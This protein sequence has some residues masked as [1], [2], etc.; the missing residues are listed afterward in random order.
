MHLRFQLV[1]IAVFFISIFQSSAQVITITDPNFR[2]ALLTH[3]P[4]ID[5]NN[6][7]L[8]QV[9]EALAAEQLYL[10]NRNIGDLTGISAFSNLK[11]LSVNNN[12]LSSID[13]SQNIKLTGFECSNN[14]LTNIDVSNN[15]ALMYFRCYGNN[16]SSIDLSANTDLRELDISSNNLTSLNLSVNPLLTHLNFS[17]NP[18]TAIN[19]KQHTE[20]ISLRCTNTSLTALDLSCNNSLLMAFTDPSSA[21]NSICLNST[22]YAARTDPADMFGYLWTKSAHTSWTNCPSLPMVTPVPATIVSVDLCETGDMTFNA[23]SESFITNPT[24][25][26]Q[27]ATSA[28]GPWVNLPGENNQKLVLTDLQ[29]TDNGSIYKVLISSADYCGTGHMEEAAGKIVLHPVVYPEVLAA[30]S[31]TGAVCDTIQQITYTATPVAGQ[32]SAPA[33]QWYYYTNPTFTPISG[34]NDIQYTPAT[35]PPNGSQLFVGMFTDEMCAVESGVPSNILTVKILPTP[36]PVI[37]TADIALCNPSG[38]VIQTSQTA[39][40]GTTFQWYKNGIAIAASNTRN[41]TISSEGTY[42]MKENNGTCEI[43]SGSVTIDRTSHVPDPQVTVSSSLTGPACDTLQRITYT[44]TPVPGTVTNPTYQWYDATTNTAI[45]GATNAVFT[46][47]TKPMN[48]DKV[49]V[50]V[51]TDEA[52]VVNPDVQSETVTT[53]ILPTPAPVMVSVSTALC[54]PAGHQLQTSNIAATGAQIIW[55]ENGNAITNSNA[56]TFTIERPGTYHITESNGVCETASA[57]VTISALTAAADPQVT[58]SSSLTGP[59]CDTLQR[60]TYTATP[61]PGTVA[62][63]TYQWYDATT[64]TAITGATNAVFTPAT[65]PMNGEKVYVIV[66]TNEACV[67][68]PDVQSETVTTTILP[69]PAPVMTSVSTALCNPAGHQL[70]TSNIAATGAQIIWYENGNAITNSN[71]STFTIE[72]PGTYHITES[73]GVCET[74]SANVTITALTAAADPQ[75]TVSSSLTGPACDTL[76]RITY[77][78]TPVAGTVTNPTY[79]WFDATTNTAITGATNEVYTPAAKPANGDKV[80]V[81]IHTDEACVANPDVQSET[82]TTT[83]LP[84][85]APVMVSRDTALC[86]PQQYMLNAQPAASASQLQWYKNGTPLTPANREYT[87]DYMDFPGGLYHIAESN[88][89]C[90]IHSDAVRIE[91]L[92]TPQLYPPDD[93]HAAKGDVITLDVQAQYAGHYQWNPAPELSSTS[94]LNP[95]LQVSKTATYTIQAT[96]NQNR[97]PVTAQVNVIITPT[98]SIPNVITVNGDGVNDT[99]E[100]ENLSHYNNAIV[101]IFNRW[102]AVV[103]KSNGYS[104]QWDGSNYNSNEALP[105]GTYFYIIRL[106]KTDKADQ[107]DSYTGYIQLIN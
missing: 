103:W 7:G 30:S 101:E 18:I 100:I 28:S 5:T 65:K 53:T 24:Y 27:K 95:V 87:I 42:Y 56:S 14:N 90:T 47:A 32:G 43:A 62:N 57:N 1:I 37:T 13:I 86:M 3:S 68:N 84:T 64:N 22:Q 99:W 34:A 20:L 102:G 38:F 48:G 67:V 23:V 55:Y 36:E 77:T 98:I 89:A 26:W 63:P 16:L 6:D 10:S 78:A 69:T 97:C 70:Q 40:A 39:A 60:I 21:L 11:G 76:Q 2:N 51:H 17:N 50:I 12:N 61:V 92:Q 19:I 106:N 59:A 46:P 44:A 80:Y 93:I 85:P 94:V 29:M 72:R 88:G 52:C 4:V 74:A 104:R 91:L 107:F 9:S 66:H 54:N 15:T 49:Y 79:Q 58:V 75:V 73:N 96:N 45:T 41:L 82:V 8:I 31:V 25:K 105:A 83:I 35:L 33:Y 81:I 71:V